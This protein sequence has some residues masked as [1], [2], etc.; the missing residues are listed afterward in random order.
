MQ[1]VVDLLHPMPCNGSVVGIGEHQCRGWERL[2]E[3][4]YDH[5]RFNDCMSIVHERRH[6]GIWVELAIFR[7]KL[8]AAQKVEDFSVPRQ[9]LFTE[10]YSYFDGADGGCGM[11]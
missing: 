3:V 7:L 10:H 5:R 2:V 6:H 1:I 11:I 9:S 4:F 8:V